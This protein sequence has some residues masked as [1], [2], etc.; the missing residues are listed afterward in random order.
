FGIETPINSGTGKKEFTALANK[1]MDTAQAGT[2][3]QAAMEFGSLQCKPVKPDCSVCP[4]QPSCIAYNSNRIDFLPVKIRS[5]KIRDRYFT[6]VVAVE[7]QHVLM[8]KRGAKDIW[9]NLYQ[10]P[11]FET[12]EPID[13]RTLLFQPEFKKCFGEHTTIKSISAPIKHLLSHQRLYVQFIEIDNFTTP[14][15]LPN[16]LFYANS[17]DF[18]TLAQPKVIFEFLEKFF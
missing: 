5:L 11:L 14:D 13:A 12:K 6:F 18:G 2:Y 3:N 9:E 7:D 15:N 17:T 10:L 8:Q 16:G 1:V 4:L